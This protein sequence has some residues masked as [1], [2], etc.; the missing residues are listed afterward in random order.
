MKSA[1]T[2]PHSA[3]SNPTA[4][5]LTPPRQGLS[6]T[7][8]HL[9]LPRCRQGLPGDGAA[10]GGRQSLQAG[11]TY[12]FSFSLRSTEQIGSSSSFHAPLASMKEMQPTGKSKTHMAMSAAI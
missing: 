5:G 12:G 7:A 8:T 6:S 9:L 2:C 4:T 11:S 1:S 3:A 10:G